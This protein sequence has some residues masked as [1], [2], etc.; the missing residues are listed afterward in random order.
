[1]S[2]RTRVWIVVAAAAAVVVAVAVIIVVATG[3]K[4]SS[5]TPSQPRKGA[6]LLLLDTGLRADPASRAL[7][8]AAVLYSKGR[9]A[10]AGRV[11]ATQHS[12]NA[13]LGAAFSN[14][15]DGALARVSEL[16]R[17]HPHSALARLH[18]GLALIWT[19]R[20]AEGVAALRAAER[21]EPDSPSAVRAGDLLHPRVAPGLP[22]FVPSFGVPAAVAK[23]PAAR[24]LSVLERAARKPD[25]RAK[26]LY[27]VALQRVERPVSAE[28]QFA[29]AAA[30][31]PGNPEAQ[32][33]AAVG[34]FDKDNPSAAFSR[35]GPLTKRFPRAPTVRFHLGLLL[36]WLNDLPDARK[37]LR[38][39]R[40]EAP[41]TPLA[42]EANRFL[43]RLSSIGTK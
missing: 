42:Q 24:Q 11:F 22:G 34:R 17:T 39:A 43:V 4:T 30:L 25:L 33:A 14:W 5:A 20:S 41:G 10:E 15:P 31:A 40:A 26:L 29:A 19:G 3:G 12:L 13:Q 35:L 9:R 21:I 6:P 28:R 7:R 16:A 37:Q 18:L 8:R 36:L 23:L 32:V 38:L 2:A 1:M 27:G